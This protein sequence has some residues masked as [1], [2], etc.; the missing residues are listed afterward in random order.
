MI[1]TAELCIFILSLWPWFKITEM[2]ERKNFDTTSFT[3]LLVH[4]NWIWY[5]AETCWSDEPDTHLISSN[6]YSKQKVLLIHVSLSTTTKQANK[7]LE[8]WLAFRYLLTDFFQNWSDD[9]DQCI[10][11]SDTSLNVLDLHSRWQLC[12][13]SNN[14]ALI[15]S[16]I[17]ESVW[18]KIM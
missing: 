9:R 4:L 10:L 7:K 17:S 16:Q 3:K 11:H 6:L 2:Q 14:A 5:A 12:G 13:K 1:N 18:I 15:F 8:C